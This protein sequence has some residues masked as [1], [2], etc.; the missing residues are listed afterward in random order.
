MEELA[1]RLP[2][3]LTC[4]LEARLHITKE[5]C[6]FDATETEFLGYRVDSEEIYRSKNNVNAIQ[7]APVP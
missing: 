1:E 3:F 5:K 4:L 6:Q 2:E 7:S